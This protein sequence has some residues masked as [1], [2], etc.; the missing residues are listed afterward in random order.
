MSSDP[1]GLHLRFHSILVFLWECDVGARGQLVEG[2]SLVCEDEA[3][4]SFYGGLCYDI[5]Y[6]GHL[7]D[8]VVD[9]RYF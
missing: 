6:S 5:G 1:R 9:E 2:D 4:G 3:E 8:A 7:V